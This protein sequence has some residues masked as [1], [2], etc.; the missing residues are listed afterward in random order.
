MGLTVFI[1]SANGQFNGTGLFLHII[2]YNQVDS[3]LTI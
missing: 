3:T 1:Y 2:V